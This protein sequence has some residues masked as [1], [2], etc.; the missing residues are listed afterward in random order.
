MIQNFNKNSNKKSSV[1]NILHIGILEAVV[2]ETN[3]KQKNEQSNNDSTNHS[4]QQ[5][6]EAVV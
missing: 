2:E 1:V 4:F 3:S 6:N 5:T